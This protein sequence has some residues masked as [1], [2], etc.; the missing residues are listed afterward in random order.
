MNPRIRKIDDLHQIRVGDTVGKHIWSMMV[1]P[2]TLGDPFGQLPALGQAFAGHGVIQ[3]EDLLFDIYDAQVPT[4]RNGGYAVVAL[5]QAGIQ[6]HLA[7]VVQQAADAG[8]LGIDLSGPALSDQMG[9]AGHRQRVSPERLSIEPTGPRRIHLRASVQDS[10]RQ[11]RMANRLKPQQD[12]RLVNRI[13][14]A[15]GTDQAL[16]TRLRIFVDSD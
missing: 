13:D 5:R 16:P 6:C 3:T 4:R 8:D 1:Q 14:I 12:H 7:N 15:R 11:N 10:N 9:R 2:H